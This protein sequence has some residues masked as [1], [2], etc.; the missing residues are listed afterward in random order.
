MIY[1]T[2]GDA[3]FPQST[4]YTGPVNDLRIEGNYMENIGDTGIDITSTK[5]VPPHQRI[6]AINN[7]LVNAHIRVSN[8]ED[9]SIIGN[10]MQGWGFIDIDNGAGVPRNI[11]VDNNLVQTTSSVALGFYGARDCQATNNRILMLGGSSQSGV[12]AAIRGVGL[13]ENN[14]IE[15][16][17]DYGISFAGWGLGGDAQLTIRKNTISGF[18][19]IGIWD[20]GLNQGPVLIENNT[21]VDPNTPFLSSYGIRTDYESNS[22][23]IQYNRV[24]AG[25]TTYISAPGSSVYGNVF[26][27]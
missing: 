16:S 3:I 4:E 6:T 10:T 25:S 13:I 23:T 8:A 11:I 12:V 27:P 14:I 22:W 2:G 20:N 19:N 26:A 7:V 24:Y 1:N 18:S 17:Q 21:I 5:G 9:I 15:G